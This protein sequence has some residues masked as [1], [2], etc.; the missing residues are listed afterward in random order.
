MTIKKLFLSYYSGDLVEVNQLASALRMRGIV[1]W[2]D[3]SGG[4]SVADECETEA[5]RAI[6]EDCFGLLLYATK[7]CFRRE[8]IRKEMDEAWTVHVADP[9]FALFAVPRC[10]TFDELAL[11]SLGDF[12]FDL[13]LTHTIRLDKRADLDLG[14]ATIARAVLHKYLE[15]TALPCTD[16]ISLQISTLKLMPDKPTDMLRIDATSAFAQGVGD[17]KLWT[18]LLGG[19]IDVEQALSYVYGRPRLHVH[20]SKHLSTAFMFGRVFSQF[21]MDIQQT[22]HKVW[23]T[24]VCYADTKP[25]VVYT[26]KGDAKTRR[27]FVEIASGDKNV[28]ACVDAFL[29]ARRLQPPLRLQLHPP[30]MAFSVDAALCRA[31]AAHAYSEIER[32]IT[33]CLISEIHIFAAV[34]QTFMILLGQQFRGMPPVHLYEWDGTG[35]TPS[36]RIPGGKL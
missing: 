36:C 3:K 15:R 29:R 23:R 20:G 32:M 33:E 5:R 1:P 16:G 17:G 13:S 22:A 7:Q 2:V 25:F 28:P 26:Q 12:G 8:F 18:Q 6:R 21:D 35:Y 31:M 24:D 14:Y 30:S 11:Y 10:I 34:P 9:S 27:L 19:L 4:F